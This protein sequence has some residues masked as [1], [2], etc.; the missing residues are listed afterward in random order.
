MGE[1]DDGLQV[2]KQALI[3]LFGGEYDFG[4]KWCGGYAECGFKIEP[5]GPDGE[6]DHSQC[7]VSTN[8]RLE[9]CSKIAVSVGEETYSFPK[10]AKMSNSL[11][12]S[13]DI[14]ADRHTAGA[15]KAIAMMA[16]CVHQPL[17]YAVCKAV[18]GHKRE[19]GRFNRELAK[20]IFQ[21]LLYEGGEGFEEAIKREHEIFMADGKD[22][23]AMMCAFERETGIS[24]GEQ[25]EAILP[26]ASGNL[27]TV[28]MVLRAL[29]A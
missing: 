5:Q 27:D 23:R 14:G 13:F 26:L 11:T 24:V 10:P 22:A 25:E 6:L 28:T 12:V 21:E 19:G 8:E 7:L 16:N 9:F 1:G 3:D 15:T 20:N 29:R 18:E 17:M 2:F 4:T